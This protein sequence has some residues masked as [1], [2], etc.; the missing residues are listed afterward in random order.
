[1]IK[2]ILTGLAFL[3][4]IST[5]YLLFWPVPVNPVAWDAPLSEGYTG[6]FE[7]NT[8]LANLE[9]LSIGDT[10]GP[11]DVDIWVDDSGDVWVYASGHQGEIIEIH[12]A[13]NTH[14][15]IA[16]TGGVPLGVEF[17]SDGV[18]YIADAYKG[19]MSVTRDGKLTLLTNSVDGTP[20]LYADDLDIAPDGVI[21]FSDASTKFGAEATGSTL[22]GSLLELLEHSKTGRI[23]AYDPKDGS[24]RIV[25]D[26][27]SFSNGVAM[28][29]E[30]ESILVNETGEYCV[31]R[32]WVSGPRAGER[33]VII[34]NMPGFPDN[35]N[36]GPIVED[37]GQTYLL[38]LVSKRSDWTDKNAKNLLA[39]K[40][41][42][43]LPPSLRLKP[44][45]H[46]MIVQIDANGTVLQTWQDSSGAYPTTTGAVIA[47]D[48]YMYVTSLTAPHLARLKLQ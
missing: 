41:A 42:L 28:G 20:I 21:Y 39:R 13:S 48:G 4:L 44:Q 27:F 18:L 29:P 15:V 2:R 35:I 40:I 9:K 7:L 19:L 38:G 24:T 1:M 6:D 43:R 11:E 32:I 26:G 31:H 46:G 33:E 8:R 14:K 23:L 25:A 37:I 47:P 36:P 22:A 30:G 16:N 45:N 17:G 5:C 12:P 34:R 10:Y 3:L